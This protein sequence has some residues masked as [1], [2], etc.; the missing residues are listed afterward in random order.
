VISSKCAVESVNGGIWLVLIGDGPRCRFNTRKRCGYHPVISILG[1]STNGDYMHYYQFNIGDYKS[2]TEHLSE[3]EDLAYRRLLDW[4][5]LHECPIPDDIPEIA[6]QIR[7]RSHSDCIAT[8]LKEFFQLTK[9]GWLSKRAEY[10][11]SRIGDK[12]AKARAS[13][14]ARWNKAKDANALRTQSEGNATQDTIHITQDTEHKKKAT[15]VACPE[16]LDVSVWQDWLKI[17]KTKKAPLT[18]TAWKLFV[19][20]CMKAG[21]TIEDAI[22]ECC[23]RNWASFKADW[24]KE[25]QTNAE[26]LSNTMST[27]TRGLTTP[28]PFWAKPDDNVLEATDV[29]LL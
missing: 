25:K 24:M 11:I 7:M 2:H 28:K 3:M 18:A 26:R 1:L 8:V 27:L 29:K 15:V 9:K 19:N 13:A 5:Y 12:S 16:G 22:K 14:E 20:E 23:L 10:E 17:R 4:Y 21:W 6:R